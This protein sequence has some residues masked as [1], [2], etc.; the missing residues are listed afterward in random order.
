MFGRVVTCA[1]CSQ[2]A[3]W[4]TFIIG[5]RVG[6]G[7]RNTVLDGHPNRPQNRELEDPKLW[8][9]QEGMGKFQ[10][11]VIKFCTATNVGQRNILAKFQP[12]RPK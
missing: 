9:L 8:A 3:G 7:H 2:I 5:T 10:A 11:I 12:N 1:D 6:V 4:V